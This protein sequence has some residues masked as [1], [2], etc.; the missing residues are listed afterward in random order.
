MKVEISICLMLLVHLMR[1]ALSLALE[2]AGKSMA[3]RM[4]MMAITTSN[5]M[6]V[7]PLEQVLVNQPDL[8]LH[9]FCLDIG[10][11]FIECS[12]PT[13]TGTK[14]FLRPR[15]FLMILQLIYGASRKNLAELVAGNVNEL[16]PLAV[17]GVPAGSQLFELRFS[18]YWRVWSPETGQLTVTFPPET[19]AV[20]TGPA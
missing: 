14:F 19:L 7:K 9:V 1:M 18:V 8:C 11:F 13:W 3:A 4:A 16:M 6:R 5:S 10:L 17:T 12:G 15:L 20:S 2:S